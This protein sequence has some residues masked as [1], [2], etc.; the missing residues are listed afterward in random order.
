MMTSQEY[1]RACQLCPRQCGVNRLD[2]E[3]GFCGETAALRIA[4]I[5]AHFG[6]EPPISGTNGSGTVFFSGCTLQC[7]FCQNYQISQQHV[8]DVWPVSAVVGRLANLV[9]RSGIHNVNFV[10]PDQFLP[11]TW[12]IV[13]ELRRRGIE[14]PSVYNISGYERVELVK[15]TEAYADMYL[16]DFKFADRELSAQLAS[17]QDYPDVALNALAEMVRQKGFLD[18]FTTTT[19]ETIARRG[20]LVRHLILPGQVANSLKVLDMLFLEFGRNLPLSLMSQ[21]HPVPPCQQGNWGRRITVPEFEEVYNH[22]LSLGL[23]HLFVQY[24]ETSTGTPAFLPDFTQERP[25]VGN[26]QANED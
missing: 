16:P 6:E 9:Q 22:A 14:L 13:A 17:C 2:G 11:H 7:A 8:G 25:F 21:Y 3:I 24:P 4:T 10:T 23:R 1:F 12:E 26:V 20:V 19:A 15:A 5:E 18:T